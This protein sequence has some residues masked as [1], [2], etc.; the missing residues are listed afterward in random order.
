[1]GGLGVALYVEWA[2]GM[3]AFLCPTAKGWRDGPAE[4]WR[5]AH[6]SVLIKAETMAYATIENRIY[7]IE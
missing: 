6:K 5:K 2:H 4:A 7:E 3:A 1:M